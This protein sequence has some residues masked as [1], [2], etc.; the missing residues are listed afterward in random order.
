MRFEFIG[1]SYSHV[2]SK[3]L[4]VRSNLIT[5]LLAFIDKKNRS[6]RYVLSNIATI[7]AVAESNLGNFS[8]ERNE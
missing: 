3:C 6:H 8:R 4:S 1:G 5:D 7:L 2:A